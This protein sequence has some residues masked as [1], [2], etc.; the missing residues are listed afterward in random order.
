[1]AKGI[2]RNRNSGREKEGNLDLFS[3][4]QA[5]IS[6]ST[7]KILEGSNPE[8]REAITHGEGPLLIIAGAGTGKTAVITRRIAYLIA[9]KKARPEEI[10][11]LT[12]TDKAAAEMEERVDVL[13][14]YGYAEVWISTFHAFGDRVLREEALEIGLDPAF[15]V[16]TRPEQVIFFREHLFEF[17]LSYYRPLGDPTRHIEAILSLFSR[18]KDEDISPAEYLAYAR[19]LVQE[20]ESRPEDRE[21]VELSQKQ[22]ELALTYQRYQ[23]LLHQRCFI[24]FG[25]QVTLTLKLFREHPSVTRRYQ[26][27]FRYILVDEFQDTNYAQWELVR[28]LAARHNNITVVGDDDQSIY[29]FRGAAI[30]NIL[31]FIK[32]YPQA[33]QIVLTRNYR[34]PQSIL[35]TAYRLIR[36]NDPERL[37]VKKAIDKR[38]KAEVPDG[39]QVTHLTFDTISSEADGVAGIIMEKV[40]SGAYS[41]G[42]FAILVRANRDADPF[43]RALNMKGIPWRF[44]GNQGL[45]SQEEVRLLISFL[46]CLADPKDSLSLFHLASSELYHMPALDLAYMSSYSKRH[47]RP[48]AWTFRHLDSIPELTEVSG[49]GRAT[50]RKVLSD[51]KAYLEYSRSHGTGEVLYHFLTESGYLKRLTSSSSYRSDEKVQ[52]LAKF[53]EQVKRFGEISLEDRV[54]QFVAHLGLLIHAGDD[55]ATAEADL[56]A[57]AINVLTVHKAKGLE[58]PVVFMVSLVSDRFP[59]RGRRDPLELPEPLIKDVLPSGDFHLQEERRLFYV[60]MT[61]AKRELYFTS[62]I[63]YG[64]PRKRKVSQFVLEALDKPKVEEVAFKA[65]PLD[66][67]ERFGASVVREPATVFA[68]PEDEIITLSH[69]QIDDYLTCPLKYKYVH[70]LRVPIRQHHSV[71]YGKAIHDAVSHYFRARLAGQPV[72]EDDLIAAFEASWSS[73][74]FITREHEEM[75][76]QAGKEALRRFFQEE[77]AKK[78]LPTYVEKPF[79]FLLG[80]NRVI[81][82]WDRID[83]KDDSVVIVDYKSSEVRDEKEA[84]RKAKESLQLSIYALAYEKAFGR[85]PDRVELRFLETGLVG[86]AV[87]TEK[88]LAKTGE[89]I[90]EVARCIRS[91]NYEARPE[92]LACS[93]CAYREI[94]PY[95][96]RE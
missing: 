39:P 47:N 10:L 60:G 82:R 90:K 66:V 94:C 68:I 49:E 41:Y 20:A 29:K 3:P 67:I 14:P 65:S 38:L 9:S 56:D 22:M 36:Q 1:M 53:F 34:S 87:K 59:S 2:R 51:I 5:P 37:E 33:R 44:S 25:D 28:L 86:A 57:D 84:H 21:L 6:S 89:M 93:Y 62:A 54:P 15:R 81:G 58:F 73:E 95:T 91:R 69:L 4:V 70:I 75:R 26:E 40:G 78:E 24:D 64:G 61:R 17:P 92:Y 52:N 74:G 27:R 80:N 72:K 55:P 16:L 43:L 46:R 71:I 63:D 30:S 42:D 45:Y 79:S 32:A 12:F 77:E 88:D 50:A 7:V 19:S 83:Q 8:Q 23:E 11:A 85:I 96:A 76:F 18:A 31:G 35:D 48:L 13:V